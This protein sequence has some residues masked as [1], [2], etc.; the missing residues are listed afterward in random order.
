MSDA[1]QQLLILQNRACLVNG[2]HLVCHPDHS[3]GY[4]QWLQFDRLTAK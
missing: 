2:I 1:I 4:Y 3:A